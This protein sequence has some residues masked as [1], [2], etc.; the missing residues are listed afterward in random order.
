MKALVRLRN[1]P[2]PNQEIHRHISPMRTCRL[3]KGRNRISDGHS[4]SERT[5][6]YPEMS[7]QAPDQNRG[8]RTPLVP[9]R[10]PEGRLGSTRSSSL[11]AR[12]PVAAVEK[13]SY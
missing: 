6:L 10:Q 4:A 9:H 3:E 1:A 13:Y 2:G 7:Q 12:R 11:A 8:R 5:G